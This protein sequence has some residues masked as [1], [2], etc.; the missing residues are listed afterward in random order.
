MIKVAHEDVKSKIHY[1]FL[2]YS[3]K[4]QVF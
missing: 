1:V 4:K 3:R 2:T